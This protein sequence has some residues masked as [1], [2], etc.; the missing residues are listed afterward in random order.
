MDCQTEEII[1]H[2]QRKSG[3][4][5]ECAL[6][7]LRKHGADGLTYARSRREACELAGD[8]QGTS[9]WSDVAAIIASALPEMDGD[10]AGAPGKA[11]LAFF[12]E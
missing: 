4:I 3:R 10:G 8:S 9:L 5:W 1:Y 7:V 12:T 11:G 2:E 6:D